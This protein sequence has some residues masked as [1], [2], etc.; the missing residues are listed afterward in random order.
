MNVLP[1]TI[2]VMTLLGHVVA[3]ELSQQTGLETL[4]REVENVLFTMSE[5]VQMINFDY[6]EDT[7]I[8]EEIYTFVS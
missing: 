1:V 7:D 3:E 6:S 8:S 5:E 4:I 2:K